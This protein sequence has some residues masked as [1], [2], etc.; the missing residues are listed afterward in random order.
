MTNK[1]DYNKISKEIVE[2]ES[3]EEVASEPKLGI[4]TDC[5]L[6]NVREEPKSDANIICTIEALTEVEIDENNSTEEFYKIYTKAGI[7]G[8]CMKKFIV[9]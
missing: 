1:T 4:V 3:V 7:E 9:V 8:F 5:I 6:L 2:V